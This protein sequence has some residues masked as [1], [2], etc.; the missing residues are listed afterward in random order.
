M[1]LWANPTLC[2]RKHT[3]RLLKRNH[4]TL[5]DSWFKHMRCDY[6]SWDVSWGKVVLSSPTQL[7]CH[8]S[9]SVK[10]PRL[11]SRTVLVT[12]PAHTNRSQRWTRAVAQ[13]TGTASLLPKPQKY[14]NSFK[15]KTKQ[16]EISLCCAWVAE[17][18]ILFDVLQDQSP[19]ASSQHHSDQTQSS[20]DF[21]WAC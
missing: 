17:L 4:S 2:T 15:K 8:D 10:Q 1:L 12:A 21:F 19:A 20:L 3:E 18:R 6:L 5:Q 13:H 7:N 14:R 11:G 9:G 16:Q